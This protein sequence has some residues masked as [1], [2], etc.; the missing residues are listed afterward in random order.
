MTTTTNKKNTRTWDGLA[1]GGTNDEQGAPRPARTRGVKP[2][3]S[4]DRIVRVDRAIRELEQIGAAFS[5]ADIAERAGTSRA[6]I[7]RDH[8]LRALIGARGD[9]VRPI[10]PNVHASVC[11]KHATLQSKARDLRQRLKDVERAWDEMRDRALDA[12][13]KLKAAEAQAK[14]LGQ[15]L[16][17]MNGT[18]AAVPLAHLASEI[19]Q[20]G[21]RRARRQLALVLHPDRFAK[22]PEVAAVASELLRAV[23]E[24]ID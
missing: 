19:G 3:D 23:N 6:T 1:T 5:V 4:Q 22:E 24:L 9:V 8:R 2:R 14:V 16:S 15:R 18:R 12:E 17:S 10:D 11:A 7:Y 20:D 21:L 13:H